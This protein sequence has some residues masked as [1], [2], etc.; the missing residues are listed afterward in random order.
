MIA[1]LL[2]AQ[3]AAA[4][5]QIQAQRPVRSDELIRTLPGKTA[6]VGSPPGHMEVSLPVKPAALYRHGDRPAKGLKNWADYPDG[7]V[8]LVEAAK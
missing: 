3:L 7:S 4:P 2:A 6:C 1:L 5:P 8:C